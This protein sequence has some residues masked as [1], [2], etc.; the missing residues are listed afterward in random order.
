MD[1]A[2]DFILEFK[3]HG[4]RMTK[5]DPYATV[6]NLIA[7]KSPLIFDVAAVALR[8]L[9]ELPIFVVD[10]LDHLEE[11]QLAK[12]A[13]LALEAVPASDAQLSILS[14]AAYQVPSALGQ[15]LA[16]LYDLVEDYDY[17]LTPAWRAAD[18]TEVK[19]L[20]R[21]LDQDDPTRPLMC[22]F[23][24]PD[25][26]VFDSVVGRHP[27][28]ESSLI[29]S[30]ASHSAIHIDYDHA[31]PLMVG[32][33]HHLHFEYNP[34]TYNQEV[35]LD[36]AKVGRREDLHPTLNLTSD[37]DFVRAFGGALE[38]TCCICGGELH[39]LMDLSRLPAAFRIRTPQ[40]VLATCLSCLSWEQD[41]L[42]YEHDDSGLPHTLDGDGEVREPQFPAEPL[43]ETVV[44]VSPTPSRWQEQ[45]MD[46]RQN[47]N[48]LGGRPTW[49]QDPEYPNCVKCDSVMPFVAQF[50]SLLATRS[51]YEWLWGS[52]GVC[53]FF[54]CDNCRVSASRLQCT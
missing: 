9:D 42:S 40:L 22:L 45:Q 53:Y 30:L 36:R 50:D 26:D 10:L 11:D 13:E 52:G 25:T 39:K 12:L 33:C 29:Q 34:D 27:A 38:D 3:K 15:Q 54:W 24:T 31:T 48:R 51:G 16:R 4:W 17:R 41:V 1:S 8:E 7:T 5:Q 23:E 46:G 37:H 47:F 18:A 6:T 43:A 21:L 2:K 49:I 19:R 28:I 20:E 32:P 35:Q 14:A 44:R